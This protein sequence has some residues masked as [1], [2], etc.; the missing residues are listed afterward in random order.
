MRPAGEFARVIALGYARFLDFQAVETAQQRLIDEMEEELQ[1]A[2]DMQMGLMPTEHPTVGGFDIAGRSMPANHVCGDF[3]QYFEQDNTLSICVADVT[4]HAMDAAIP[5]VMFSGVLD[6]QMEL[7]G[8][9]NELFGR[10]N[11]SMFRNLDRRTFVCFTM[12]VLE[13]TTRVL[14]LSNG[15]CPYAYHFQAS[16]AEM[17]ELQ[18]DAYPLGVRANTRHQVVEVRLQPGDRIIFCSDGIPE[19]DNVSGEKFGYDRT[20]ATILQA[21]KDGLS[22]EA[23]IDH[24]LAEVAAFKGDAPQSDDMTC[25]VLRVEE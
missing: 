24:I 12:G 11:S 3:F 5:A 8:N 4:G 1:T 15:G 16:R 18:V 7:E 10:L 9:L 17:A 19:A 14:R 22:A 21:C 6:S 13:P 23:T 25:V 2:H 20:H